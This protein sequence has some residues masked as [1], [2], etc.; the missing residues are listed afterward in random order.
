MLPV[1]RATAAALFAVKQ[2]SLTADALRSAAS[3][4]Y[5]AVDFDS[6]DHAVK[7]ALGFAASEAAYAAAQAA[8]AG[9]EA[10]AGAPAAAAYASA[11]AAADAVSSI[12]P[13]FEVY[14]PNPAAEYAAAAKGDAIAIAA[15]APAAGLRRSRLWTA[16][17]PDWATS[18]WSELRSA[19]PPKEGWQVWID[20]YE[21]RLRGD[22]YDEGLE[23]CYVLIPEE[24]WEQ[25]PA[26]A[27]AEIARRIA[28]YRERQAAALAQDPRGGRFVAGETGLALRPGDEPAA[29]EAAAMAPHVAA[30]LARLLERLRL[31]NRTPPGLLATV[32][33]LLEIVESGSDAARARAF[34]MWTQ[35]LALA[36]GRA[37]DDAVKGDPTSLEEPLDPDSR[38]ALEVAVP[39]VAVYIR[40]FD[41][42]RRFDEAKHSFDAPVARPSTQRAVVIGAVEVGALERP[43]GEIVLKL[44]AVGGGSDQQ[45]AK[46]ETVGG[47]TVRNLVMKAAGLLV[48]G[49]ITG[50]GHQ[51][52]AGLATDFEMPQ[53]LSRFLREAWSYIE[54]LL[55]GE[56][57]DVRQGVEAARSIEPTPFPPSPKPTPRP[58]D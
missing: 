6:A 42:V 56:T 16:D 9:A 3:A 31:S 28:A 7:T 43:S 49:A 58:T 20:W 18:E 33:T 36:Q 22:P 46:A 29:D 32:A 53:R 48:A 45:A 1:L 14:A 52:G 51:I 40:A 8:A 4:A 17:N 10:D 24:I 30:A 47:I 38:S 19:L 26:V 44:V 23:E 11:H 57:A 39:A 2:S 15:G 12:A 41:E 50:L 34:E 21:A 27:N 25:G 13:Y 37:R 54:E 5:A 55:A 35:S